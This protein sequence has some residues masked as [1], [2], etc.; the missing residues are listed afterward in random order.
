MWRTMRMSRFTRADQKF[1]SREWSM[2][3]SER[4]GLSGLCWMSKAVTF[5]C[6]CSWAVSRSRDFVKRKRLAAP[7]LPLLTEACD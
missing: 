7:L 6:V 4:P 2:R 1:G 3:W 5:V